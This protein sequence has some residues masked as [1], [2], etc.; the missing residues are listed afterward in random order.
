MVSARDSELLAESIC[1]YRMCVREVETYDVSWTLLSKSIE[2]SSP[3]ESAPLEKTASLKAV[4]VMA[5]SEFVT[6]ELKIAVVS[7]RAELG[8]WILGLFGPP[9]LLFKAACLAAKALNSGHLL[10]C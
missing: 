2:V 8:L 6:F 4:C 1:H 9:V 10:A 5:F 7:E 3:P